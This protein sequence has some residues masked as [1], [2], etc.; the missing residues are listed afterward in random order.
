VQGEPEMRRERRRNRGDPP[1]GQEIAGDHQESGREQESADEAMERDVQILAA[2]LEG[3]VHGSSPSARNISR[4]RRAVLMQTNQRSP[5]PA[6]A[7]PNHGDGAIA[8]C[9]RPAGVLRLAPGQG[10]MKTPNRAGARP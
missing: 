5:P 10:E 6:G 3:N 8:P 1:E 2:S 9:R 7:S 4:P